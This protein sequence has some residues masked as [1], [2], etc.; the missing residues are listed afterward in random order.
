MKTASLTPPAVPDRNESVPVVREKSTDVKS[1]VAPDMPD[2][3][4]Q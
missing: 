4:D 1:V 3:S 2:L